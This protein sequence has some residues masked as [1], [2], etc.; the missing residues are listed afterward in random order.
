MTLLLHS[1]NMEKAMD[2]CL[3]ASESYGYDKQKD[4][5]ESFVRQFSMSLEQHRVNQVKFCNFFNFAF[6]GLCISFISL[7]YLKNYSRYANFEGG[8]GKLSS[9]RC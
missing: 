6:F 1:V 5:L 3:Y 2:Y 4:T 9:N 7:R 8:I